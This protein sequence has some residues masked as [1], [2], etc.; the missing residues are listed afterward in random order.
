MI[1]LGQDHPS[2]VSSSILSKKIQ[3]YHDTAAI[4]LPF[5]KANTS[6]HEIDTSGGFDKTFE[7][8]C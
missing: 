4:L 2:Y 7:S 5:L 8:I 3:Q 1:E 6:F